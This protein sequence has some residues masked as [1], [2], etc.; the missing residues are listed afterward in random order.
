MDGLASCP[1]R[2]GQPRSSR[3]I[4]Q[5]LSWAFARSPGERNF[6]CALFASFGI[7][8]CSCPGRDLGVRAA[9]VALSARVTR[10]AFSS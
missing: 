2:H 6:A 7:Q 8:A 4:L 9:P 5:V 3:R 1:A 10:S